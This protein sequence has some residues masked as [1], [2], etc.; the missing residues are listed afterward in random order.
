M[1][2]TVPANLRHLPNIPLL[3]LCLASTTLSA[4]E[5]QSQPCIIDLD[6]PTD[7]T[8]YFANDTTP[9][10]YPEEIT[11]QLAMVKAAK[12]TSLF[13]TQRVIDFS[14]TPDLT[15]E[16][17]NALIAS[18]HK[19]PTPPYIA[20]PNDDQDFLELLS[21]ADRLLEED[22]PCCVALGE[23]LRIRVLVKKLHDTSFK[24]N[25]LHDF[26]QLFTNKQAAIFIREIRKK[27]AQPNDQHK[28]YFEIIHAYG[29]EN[30]T[31]EKTLFPI[32]DTKTGKPRLGPLPISLQHLQDAHKMPLIKPAKNREG[33]IVEY[34]SLV[35]HPERI[36]SLNGF[37][38]LPTLIVLNLN[39][40]VLTTLPADA[41]KNTPN[42]DTLCL[43]GCS[44]KTIDPAAFNG[45]KKLCALNLSVNYL[46]T[47][48]P[49]L[50][51]DLTNL[52]MLHLDD[53]EL[54]ELPKNAFKSMP[55]LK[56]LDLH[57]NKF[58][59]TPNFTRPLGC[60]VTFKP[61]Y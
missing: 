5:H 11:N 41:F 19:K 58:K 24:T 59:E 39:F 57:E 37:P 40:S 34:G 22:D 42:L 61:K 38:H 12:E 52:W 29:F 30:K 13:G 47:I 56:I 16:K 4:A 8:I 32:P 9:H 25:N 44:I 15:A 10:L 33:A 31:K 49:E 51:K 48:N 7:R 43:M 6:R 35:L 3:L 50:F 46:T 2:K 28:S 54:T 17:F 36:N 20:I 27:A 53:N 1:N 23:E 21:T 18:M 45:L 14:H 26:F 60:K 55:Y